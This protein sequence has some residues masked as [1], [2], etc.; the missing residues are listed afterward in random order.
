METLKVLFLIMIIS[1]VLWGQLIEP[2]KQSVLLDVRI[3]GV[4]LAEKGRINSSYQVAEDGCI[5]MWKVGKIETREKT[6][7]ELAVEIAAAYKKAGIYDHPVFTVKR[8][9][10]GCGIGL[11]AIRLEGQIKT[12]GRYHWRKG[13]T[14]GGAV[15]DAGGATL[16]G[17][18]GRVKLF[19]NGKVF[20]FNLG[21]EKHR[22]VK[23]YPMDLIEVPQK[24][25]LGKEP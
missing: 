17:A 24:N 21:I 9:A 6:Y 8:T 10:Q 13:D 5:T 20:I 15:R 18:V 1:P 19:R 25:T 22:G 14:L 3:D 11:P 23:I 16:Y 2:K 7:E 4:S 12:A